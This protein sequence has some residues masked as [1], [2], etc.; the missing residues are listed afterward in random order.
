[1]RCINCHTV[2]KNRKGISII[3]SCEKGC[4]NKTTAYKYV[5]ICIKYNDMNLRCRFVDPNYPRYSDR[6]YNIIIL[7]NKTRDEIVRIPYF[8]E[9]GFEENV[10]NCIDAYSLVIFK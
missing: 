7:D 1:M 9:C 4:M 8:K 3:Q 5:F 10:K 2:I 6:K